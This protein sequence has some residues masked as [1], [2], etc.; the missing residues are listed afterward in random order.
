M[1]D[2]QKNSIT[3]PDRETWAAFVDGLGN[4]PSLDEHLAQCDHCYGVVAAL[5]LSLARAEREF[6]CERV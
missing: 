2:Q 4:G 5:R 3:C 1:A 6:R